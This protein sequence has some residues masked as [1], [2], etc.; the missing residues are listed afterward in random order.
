[1][2]V[3]KRLTDKDSHVMVLCNG[4]RMLQ[5]E[6]HTAYQQMPEGYRAEL[7]GGIVFEPSPLGYP[8]GRSDSR[9]NYLFETYV[10]ATPGV[11]AASNATV[12]LGDEDEVQPDLV[13]RVANRHKGQS[14]AAKYIKGA[15]ELVAEIAH[16]SR[17]IDLHFKKERYALAGVLEYVVV[18]LE[19][20]KLYWFD[21]QKNAELPTD[22]DGII[23]SMVFPGLWIH[24]QGLLDLDH[25]QTTDAL[26]SGLQSAEYKQYKTKLLTLGRQ[27]K[28]KQS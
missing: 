7:I 1:M 28:R 6:F 3:P 24:A 10:I 8:H 12:I 23:R 11:E 2:A 13:L 21:L 17:A 26:N 20:K 19:P 27:R 18:S 4:D 14:R 9:L 16:S 22:V 25:V 15:P 5:P